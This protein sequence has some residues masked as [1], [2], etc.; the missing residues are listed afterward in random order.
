MLSLK[1]PLLR[2]INRYSLNQGYLRLKRIVEI[3]NMRLNGVSSQNE[4]E[5]ESR[6]AL[7]F[8]VESSPIPNH[9]VV[10]EGKN[11]PKRPSESLGASTFCSPRAVLSPHPSAVVRGGIV[12]GIPSVS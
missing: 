12:E 8:C 9:R 1:F 10:F 5:T 11:F 7:S 3:V 2:N 4:P 6:H